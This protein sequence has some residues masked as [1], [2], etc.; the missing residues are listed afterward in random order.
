LITESPSIGDSNM[1]EGAKGG[2]MSVEI[3]GQRVPLTA[4]GIQKAGA[5]K[6][7][8]AVAAALGTTSGE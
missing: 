7:K 1:A 8:E 3:N 6:L 4:E 2:R 5:K